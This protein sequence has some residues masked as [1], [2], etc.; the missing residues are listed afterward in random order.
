[1]LPRN[2]RYITFI[3]F[4][5]DIILELSPCRFEVSWLGVAG[6]FSRAMSDAIFESVIDPG[7][8]TAVQQER[9]CSRAD[10]ER[11]IKTRTHR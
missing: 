10:A 2:A 11:F 6:E 8:I 4:T 5:P 7:D 3:F 1:V 9:K